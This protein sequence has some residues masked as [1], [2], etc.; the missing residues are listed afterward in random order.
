MALRLFQ[1]MYYLAH[2]ENL[3]SILERGILSHEQVAQAG[4]MRVD[5]S[6][7]GA[8]RWRAQ[9]EPVFGRA[10]HAYVPLYFNPRNPMLFSRK[11]L[12]HQLVVLRVSAD[13]VNTA[14]QALFTDGNAACRNTRFSTD[15]DVLK[16]AEPVLQ[17]PYWNH[18]ADGRR[19]RCAEALVP[20]R[21]APQFIDAVAC[22]NLP[23]ARHLQ[24]QFGLAAQ[25]DSSL[26]F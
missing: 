21:V 15:F 16:P 23:L 19:L 3:G 24:Q 6:E 26:F 11:Y 20:N 2:Y 4:L 14:P 7:P 8:Q 13:A 17:A 10:I 18:F 12:Q 22:N 9:A 1:E 25:V 5:I